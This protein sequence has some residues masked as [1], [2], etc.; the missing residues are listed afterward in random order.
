MALMA[1]VVDRTGICYMT[2]VVRDLSLSRKKTV[3]I[4]KP[5]SVPKQWSTRMGEMD[6]CRANADGDLDKLIAAQITMCTWNGDAANVIGINGQ[7]VIT[8]VGRNHD[9]SYDS[10]DVPVELVVPE[11]NTLF[12]Y[13][14]TQHH[15][16]EVQW[17]GMVLLLR[18]DVPEQIPASR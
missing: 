14:N 9:L 11:I 10:F 15:G 18:F 12:T 17:P 2:P 3:R 1:R 6:Y 7:K 4:C 5:Y 13:S 16:I 8:K